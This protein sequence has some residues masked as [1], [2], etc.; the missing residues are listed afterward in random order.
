MADEDRRLHWDGARWQE[1]N[2]DAWE[3]ADPQPPPPLAETTGSDA[4]GADSGAVKKSGGGGCIAIVVIILAIGLLA[5]ACTSL[6]GGKKD[7]YNEYGA[8]GN[9]KEKMDAMLKAPA[10][11]G[12]PTL[13][14]L[15]WSKAGSTWTINGWVDSENGFGAKIRTQFVC[16]VKDVGGGKVNVSI[17]PG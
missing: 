9:C 7:D 2:G 6:S 11:A 4:G 1:W 15:K 3:T 10:S 14:E 5:G 16:T 13:N 8:W 12:Y 17:D